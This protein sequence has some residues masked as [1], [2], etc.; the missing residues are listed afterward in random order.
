MKTKLFD[1]K[2]NIGK[3]G[4]LLFYLSI[5]LEL[6]IVIIDKSNYTNPIEGQLFRITFLLAAGKV[7]CTKYSIREWAAMLLFG[8]LGFV[9]YRVTGRNEILRIVVFIA[10]CKGTDM[11]KLLKY[12]FY[13]TTAGCLLL[14]IL[15]VTGIYGRLSLETDFGRGYIQVRYCFGLGHPNALHC[16]FMMLVLLGL[17]LYNEKMKWYAY[18]ILFAMNYAL[19]LL[20]D[21]NTG[22]LI[23]F[24]GI[25]GG[26][27]VHYWKGI[28]GK[29]WI[30]VAGAAVFLFCVGFSILAANK[31][32]AKPDYY[33]FQFN[34]PLIARVEAHLN[35][36]IRDLYFGSIRCEG[37]TDT[38]SLFS[39]PENDYYFDMGFV[40]VFYWYGIVP[41][42]LFVLLNILLIRRFYEEKDGMGLVML[43]V[44][45]VYTVVEAHLVSVY[46]G[47]NYLLF[48][49][50][51]YGG[52]LPGLCS[53]KEEYLWNAFRFF[54][55]ME[56]L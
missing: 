8:L 50:G 4:V 38:W 19:Y 11:K 9:S 1:H 23:T 21:S 17:Y 45:S 52:C 28:K 46:I 26:A 55:K 40:R 37:I 33:I 22:M 7:L 34:N 49:M 36:R 3:L 12:V 13:M 54:G 10:A 44:L 6:I 41:G 31:E 25:F 53:D 20:T 35:G 39:Q 2:L 51:M 32:F 27:V 43:S 29:K 24:C 47:R 18:I 56:K 30:Y 15:S 5:T 16:M 42:S 14:V 48:L